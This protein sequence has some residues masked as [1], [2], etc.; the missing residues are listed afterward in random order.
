MRAVEALGGGGMSDIIR[1]IDDESANQRLISVGY[2]H[3]SVILN[4]L[5]AITFA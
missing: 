2:A 3:H 4:S 5:G 1:L